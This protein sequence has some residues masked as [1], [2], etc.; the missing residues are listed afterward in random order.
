MDSEL[1]KAILSLDV[2][3]RGYLPDLFLGEFSDSIGT[4]IGNAEI[5]RNGGGAEAQSKGFYA[6]AYSYEGETI[7]SYRGTDELVDLDDPIIGGDI[8]NGYGV[9]AGSPEGNQAALAFQFYRQVADALANE[10]NSNPFTAN[11]ALTGHSLGGG[12]A[13]LVGAVYH[14]SGVL[15]N[16]MPFEE[17]AEAATIYAAI[18][19]THPTTADASYIQL[20]QD[21][22]G[23]LA[24]SAIS[25]SYLKTW[26]TEGEFLNLLRE[27]TSQDTIRTTLTL[28]EDVDLP[29]ADFGPTSVSRHSMATEVML[30]Y[31]MTEGLSNSWKT[32]GK[33]F[34]PVLY[35]NEFAE[36]IGATL[37]GKMNVSGN[38]A[39]ILRTVLAYSALEADSNGD[40]LLFGNTGIHALFNDALDFGHAV[41]LSNASSELSEA[42]SGISYVFTQYAG[43]LA[44]NHV[45]Q[46]QHPGVTQG[47]LN[48]SADNKT[49]TIDLTGPAWSVVNTQA[50]MVQTV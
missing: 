24:P 41:E 26:E 27:G 21:I 18:A 17:A 28:G 14:K 9:G 11:I 10:T 48:L 19:N 44:L 32:V 20:W 22:Y 36:D 15:F 7:I 25:I 50:I 47:V 43:Q 8:W 29:G 2:Y 6:A 38:Y 39:G 33:Y 4:K 35:E 31:A 45:T 42:G 13:G 3:N 1:L 23:G 37:A 49:L 12:L 40:G 46:T 30:M 34:W 5:Y 16:N